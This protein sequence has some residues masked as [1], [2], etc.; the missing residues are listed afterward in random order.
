[1]FHTP[2]CPAQRKTHGNFI[3]SRRWCMPMS[4]MLLLM[5]G[6][7][8]LSGV[9]ITAA[10]AHADWMRGH[11]AELVLN[12]NTKI[13]WLADGER[14]W[15]VERDVTGAKRFML[16]NAKTGQL[17]PVV[18]HAAVAAALTIMQK[19][20]VS[21][22]QLPI[23][24]IAMQPDGTLVLAVDR[25][26]FAYEAKKK[27]I[28]PTTF[29]TVLSLGKDIQSSR[30]GGVDSVITIT[31]NTKGALTLRWIDLD[32]KRKDYGT[33][34]AGATQTQSTYAGHVWALYTTDDNLLG[35]VTAAELPG[36]ITLSDNDLSDKQEKRTPAQSPD[37]LWTAF[38]RGNNLWL[39]DQAKKE[40]QLTRDG[41]AGDS[42]RMP[43][44]WSPTSAHLM[45]KK[46]RAGDKRTIT[47]VESSPADQLQPKV[48]TVPYPKPGDA[49]DVPQL[50]LVTIADKS[51][52]AVATKECSNPWDITDPRWDADGRAFSCLYNERGHQLLRLL[53]ITTDGMTQVLIDERSDTFINYSNKTFHAFI[54]QDR[55][56]LWASERSGWNHLYRFDVA[57]GKILNAVTS[58]E[59]VVREVEFIDEAT[60]S[61][62]LQVGGRIAQQ[63]PYYVQYARVQFDGTGFTMLTEGDGTHAI[64]WSP[65]RR[66]LIDTWSRVDQ[67]PVQAL[68]DAKSGRLIC[69]LTKAED[70]ALVAKGWARPER[71]TAPGRDGKTPIYGVIYRPS[72]MTEKDRLPIIEKIYAGPH[73]SHVPKAFSA[74]HSAQ[75]MAE[76]GF[77]VVQIDG[78]GTNWRS[79]AFHDVCWRNLIDAGFPDR[80]P[81]IKAATATRPWMDLSRVGIYGGSAGGQNALAA[82]LTRGD[83]YRAAVADCG[84]HD[85]RMD[86][87]WWNEA[88]M[89][90]PIGPHY[91]AN[92]NVTLAH[93]LQGKL[94]LIVGELDKNVDPA[95]TMQ[96]VNALIKAD[97]DFD[98]V[99]IPG[100]GHGAAGTP[101]GR[102]REEDF[103][104]KAFSVPV[105]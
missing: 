60:Q 9:D 46:V 49:I 4:V 50:H 73:D 93:H 84:C 92:S 19:R 40:Q 16:A 1:M 57:S 55:A 71:F 59:W 66:Y 3:L 28:S 24:N 96:V 69:A 37:G 86:K 68:R 7:I 23:T 45:L 101:Y 42:Y 61:L 18:D 17:E 99:I 104:I 97:K 8:T 10:R 27:T 89:G 47:I 35:V 52:A 64:K 14:C 81:W 95:S 63:D 5:L 43:V 74:W 88:W 98:F 85:N 15:F 77:V 11:A 103:F 76:L 21:A 87:I 30:G 62:V 56:V 75:R 70:S 26:W 38:V 31:N 82:L 54:D 72:W 51:V 79:K 33:I 83:F 39:R 12:L 102:R 80:I 65:D 41:T 34:D 94:M 53:R 67:A 25:L 44:W 32:G 105:R 58:G 20:E 91:A 6:A 29:N 2:I 90:W 78:M 36:Q 13:Q 22:A 100:A 48:L